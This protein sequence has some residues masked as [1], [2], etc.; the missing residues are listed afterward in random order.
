MAR[1]KSGEADARAK[2][3]EAYWELLSQKEA[4]KVTVREVA[5]K[6]GV[7]HNSFYYHF[8][9]MA[10]LE[11]AVIDDLVP[12]EYLP[13]ALALFRCGKLKVHEFPMPDD[14]LLRFRRLCALVKHASPT[15]TMALKEKFID[16]WMTTSGCSYELLDEADRIELAF[17]FGG[18][19]SAVEAFGESASLDTFETVISHS[20]GQGVFGTL[21]RLAEKGGGSTSC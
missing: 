18:L 14:A 21:Q 6:A 15:A 17:I 20:L 8:S 7:N 5:R 11:L 4:S 9:D 3:C 16:L 10:A 1:P 12:Y 19:L 13:L 2:I